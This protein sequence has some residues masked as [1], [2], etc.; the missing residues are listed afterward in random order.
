MLLLTSKRKHLGQRTPPPHTQGRRPTFL[1]GLQHFLV[2]EALLQ[3]LL[4]PDA[5]SAAETDRAMWEAGRWPD[6]RAWMVVR[7]F[8][9]F[10]CW[11]LMW[12]YLLARTTSQAQAS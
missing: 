1:E 9:P 6:R 5:P 2:V 10:L 11:I 8:L 12:T 4:H 7:L 3:S